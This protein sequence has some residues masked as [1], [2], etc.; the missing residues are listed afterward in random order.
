[1]Y[2]KISSMGG[3]LKSSFFSTL[4]L[5]NFIFT[6]C[7][8]VLIATKGFQNIETQKTEAIEQNPLPQSIPGYMAQLK[9]I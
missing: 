7:F 3:F 4:I 2:A 6:F 1:M 9:N 5:F 8:L